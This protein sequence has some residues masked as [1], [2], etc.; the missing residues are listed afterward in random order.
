MDPTTI[1]SLTDFYR[2]ISG[3][4]A[5]P[6]DPDHPFYV[7]IFETRATEDPIVRLRLNIEKAES[8]SVH[9]LTGFRGNGKSTQLRRLKKCLEESGSRVFLVDMLNYL[10]MSKPI[11]PSDFILSLMAA[12]AHAA[13][14]AGLKTLSD[15][16]WQRLTRFLV[17]EVHLDG[18]QINTPAVEVGLKLKTDPTFKEKIQDHLRGHI[19]GLVEEARQFVVGLVGE[20]RKEDPDKKVVLL[21]DSVELLRR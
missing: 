7:P 12:L 1:K 3:K 9:L 10:F 16:Y 21:V 20:I 19:T 5:V 4:N 14:E 11:E 15:S 6:L 8:E 17:S 13:E 2:S 18:I